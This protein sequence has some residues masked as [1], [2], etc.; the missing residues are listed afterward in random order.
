LKL[1]V[2]EHA[3]IELLGIPVTVFQS[4]I[5]HSTK[6]LEIPQLVPEDA[7][8]YDVGTTTAATTTKMIKMMNCRSGRSI[9]LRM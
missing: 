3:A 2:L 4:S 5:F 1:A 7:T 6:N 9:N 8:R